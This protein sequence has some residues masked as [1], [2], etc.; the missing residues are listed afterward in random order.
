MKGTQMKN[1]APG[2]NGEEGLISFSCDWDLANY[3][4]ALIVDHIVC[5]VILIASDT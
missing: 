4:A 3:T 2:A 1:E 5:I